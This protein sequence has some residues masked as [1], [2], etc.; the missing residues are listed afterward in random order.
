MVALGVGEVVLDRT[1]QLNEFPS[2]GTK[3]VPLKTEF[4]VGGP[5]AS[6]LILLSKLGVE[7]FLYASVGDDE[8]GEIIKHKLQNAGVHLITNQVKR[9]KTHNVLVNSLNGSRTIIKDNNQ[10]QLIKSVSKE[11]IEQADIVLFDRHEPNAFKDVMEKKAPDTKIIVDPSDEVSGKTI[12]MLKAASFPIMP[13]EALTKFRRHESLQKNLELA[14]EIAQKPLV[15]TCGGDGSILFE[16]EKMEVFPAYDLPIV[17]TLGAGDVF[18]GAF[19]FGLIQNWHVSK[20]VDFANMVA[21]L[22][23]TKLGNSDAI[24]TMQE[25]EL[26]KTQAIKKQIN[27][28]LFQ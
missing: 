28:N 2:E 19:A 11:L 21:G 15:I 20:I 18:R 24:P 8:A 25:I 13:I 4:S 26:C 12:E 7:C 16:G 3:I 1:I 22:Q 23:C 17:D 14:Y 5:V 10:R 9:T 27:F 6:A